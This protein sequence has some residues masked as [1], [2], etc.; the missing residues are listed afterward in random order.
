MS[1][2]AL[3]DELHER[4]R[5]FAKGAVCGRPPESFE[6]LAVAIARYQ[7]AHNPAVASL[8]RHHGESVAFAAVAVPADAF[9]RGRI[10]A[11]PES[12]DAARFHTSGT[13]G[14]SGVHAFRTLETYRS[15]ALLWGRRALLSHLPPNTRVT[16]LAL[17]PP[18]EP[19]RRSSLGFM[20]QEFMRD[21]DGRRLAVAAR[22]NAPADTAAPAFDALEP[23]RWLLHGGRID[24]GALR[25]AVSLAER[26]AE[27][28][29][30]LATSFALV[31][32]LEELAGARV[33]LSPGSVV[34]QTGGFKTHARTLDEAEL[35]ARVIET[36]QIEPQRL[37]G[38]YGMT[39]LSSQLYATGRRSCSAAAGVFAAPPWLRVTP[40]SPI[41]LSPVPSGEI[42]I[43]RFTD[44]G[45]VDSA[46]C[47][48]TQ[49]RVRAVAGGIELLGRRPG[50][51]LRGCS[52]AIDELRSVAPRA[53][54]E[55]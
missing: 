41:D 55:P 51:R 4:V 26:R 47:V 39:E 38:E 23:G 14:G 37:I 6:E 16:V 27:P 15:L 30:L 31:W 24:V 7:L 40:V 49:D 48:L 50:A 1:A 11:H 22:A 8:A 54:P 52:L 53:E 2:F 19:A 13:T 34:M 20:M 29:L 32:L 21:F 35:A 25:G 36:F 10:A 33:P 18:F 5:R 44:L 9:R 43:A 42:G 12:A 45:N 46:L 28:V 17:A 3:S